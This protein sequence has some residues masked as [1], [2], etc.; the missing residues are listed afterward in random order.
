MFGVFG[1]LV[2]PLKDL[3][4]PS[5]SVSPFWMS[6]QTCMAAWAARAGPLNIG[7]TPSAFLVAIHLVETSCARPF[8]SFELTAGPPTIGSAHL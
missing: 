6:S 2:P 8:T 4:E 7:H 1:M 5:C 3:V